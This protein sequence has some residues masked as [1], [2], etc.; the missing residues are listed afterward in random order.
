[1]TQRCARGKE[2]GE[3]TQAQHTYGNHGCLES[4]SHT[5]TATF[6]QCA[7]VASQYGSEGRETGVAESAKLREDARFWWWVFSCA[8][9][10]MRAFKQPLC[11]MRATQ[12][13]I[14]MRIS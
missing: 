8:I 12:L 13:A 7:Q 1:M 3:N 9:E 14:L 6:A 11:Q 5:T 10:A 4:L 2:D